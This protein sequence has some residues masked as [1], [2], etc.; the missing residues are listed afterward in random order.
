MAPAIGQEI[1]EIPQAVVKLV[2]KPRHR[3]GFALDN[4]PCFVQQ[5]NLWRICHD[6]FCTSSENIV[7]RVYCATALRKF[8]V[9][10]QEDGGDAS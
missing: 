6:L 8:G 9:A 10:L 5:I 4:G 2:P 7:D 1:D 3:P